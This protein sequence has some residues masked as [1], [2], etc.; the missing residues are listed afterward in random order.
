MVI[1]V[2]NVFYVKRKVF[3]NEL[4]SNISFTVQMLK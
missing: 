2:E 4:D 1:A 3:I